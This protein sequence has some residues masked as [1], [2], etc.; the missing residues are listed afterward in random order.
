MAVR[1]SAAI[2]CAL[3]LVHDTEAHGYLSKPAPRNVLTEFGEGSSNKQ[4]LNGGF[5]NPSGINPVEYE[6]QN[7][8]GL[9]GDYVNRKAFSDPK[10]E[11]GNAAAKPL[12]SFNAGDY[13][14]L[15]VVLTAHHEGWFE[16]RLCVPND[17]G[18]SLESQ[19]TQE[20][21]NKHV[22]EMD[23]AHAEKNYGKEMK[24]RNGTPIYTSPA[25]YEGSWGSNV[26]TDPDMMGKCTWTV[27]GDNSTGGLPPPNYG[28]AKA[29]QGHGPVGT[30]CNGGGDC[31]SGA[32][33]RW[34]VP[35]EAKWKEDTKKPYKMRYKLPA[36][37]VAE[38]AVLQWTYQTSN[39]PG[40]YPEMFW[41]CADIEIV[42]GTPTKAPAPT[43]TAPTLKP[44]STPTVTAPT[45]KP[46][47][48]PSVS[49]PTTH[50]PAPTTGVP[51]STPPPTD[52]CPVG[53][54]RST[55][56]YNA[57]DSWCEQTACDKAYV[58]GG[59]CYCASAPTRNLRAV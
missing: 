12:V 40:F 38:R 56:V 27:P 47:S 20:C 13:M 26:W 17:G 8:H 5:A 33:K 25:D 2:A 37:V 53:S 6:N 1:I 18:S 16:F 34:R 23:V 43:V 48:K 11:Q 19:L 4:S 45:L 46:T 10:A 15:E 41:N 55:G 36:G 51:T 14:D 21:F 50:A 57:T 31:D 39:S 52:S 54:C 42:A 30:C 29:R 9:C 35:S 24:Q 3:A 59:V 58:D 32:P 44:T 22:L 7:G 28:S 49:T